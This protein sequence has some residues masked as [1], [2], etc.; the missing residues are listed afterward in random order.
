[1]KTHLLFF[2]LFFFPVL[3]F[4]Q[5]NDPVIMSVNGKDVKKSEFEYIYNKNNSEG[6]IDKKT[7]EEYID[8]FKNFKLKVA[9]AE[10]QGIDTTAA[11]KSELADYRYQLANPYLPVPAV[12]ES[13]LQEEYD[14]MKDLLQV[15][16]IQVFFPKNNEANLPLQLLPADT[17]EPYK[18]ISQA[19]SRL[20]KGENFGKIVSEYSE[21]PGS[22]DNQGNLGWVSG[23]V[24]FPVLED[25]VFSLEVGQFSQP[26]RTSH[27]YH[28]FKVLSKK[29]NPGK[30][31]ASHILIPFPADADE[32]QKGEALT[33]IEDIYKKIIVGADFAE[34]AREHSQ[35]GSASRGGDLGWFG[36]GFMVPDFEDVAFGLQHV[37]EVSKPFT[38]PFGYHIVKLSDRKPLEPYDIKKQEIESMFSR[39][40]FFILLHRPSIENLKK[41]NHFAKNDKAYE[42]LMNAATELYP[43]SD[44]YIGKFVDSNETLFSFG[45]E[46]ISI[47]EFINYLLEKEYTSHTL[48]TDI[49]NEKLEEFEYDRMVQFEDESLER[50]YPDFRNLMREYRDGILMF[51]VT[52]KEVWSRASEDAEGLAQFFENNASHYTWTEP[53]YKGYVVLVKDAA[54]KKEIQKKTAKMPQEDA[55]NYMLENYKVGSVSYVRVEKGLFKKGDNAFVDEVVFKTGKAQPTENFGDFFVVGKML[56]APESY[57][58]VRGQ[59]ITDYQDYLEAEWLKKLNEKYP[60]VLYKDVIFTEK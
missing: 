10:A 13:L 26:I 12:D 36:Y 21:D 52:D 54:T 49:L 4:A 38:S 28:I 39:G 11:F 18:K 22:K 20:K 43:M 17:L 34:M 33:R 37:G 50:K 16:H 14:R 27:G 30:I 15:A 60:V 46:K 3:I 35:D 55:I 23:M 41:E 8:L 53:H 5:D 44:E 25:A 32:T 29:P 1:M 57:L 31:K 51:E 56:N 7:F 48:S 19:Y 45:D 9:E 2:V 47:A 59:V 24:L 58:D 6:I 40:G 42:S